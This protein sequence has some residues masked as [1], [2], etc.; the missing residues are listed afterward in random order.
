VVVG[1]VALFGPAAAALVTAAC[2]G[3][4]ELGDL[5]ARVGRWRVSIWWYAVALVLPVPISILRC[6]VERALGAAG[7]FEWQAVSALSVVV[8]VMVAGEEIG[9]R[10]FA[11][12]RLFARMGAWKASVVL[13]AL[14]AMWHLPLFY[15]SGMPQQGSP[16]A[17]YVVYVIGLSIIL[18]ILVQKTSGS[19]VVATVFHGAV[20]TFGIVAAGATLTQRGWSNAVSYGIV[21]VVLGAVAWRGRRAGDAAPRE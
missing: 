18:T 14:W 11:L 19:V 7:P 17:P 10:G 3:K 16:F 15:M 6:A 1:L 20:N 13:G 21:A 5:R 9:W 8:F 2:C 4:G 12:P